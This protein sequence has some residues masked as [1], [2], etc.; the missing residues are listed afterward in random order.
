MKKIF[1]EQLQYETFDL[2]NS[3]EQYLKQNLS[4]KYFHIVS[5]KVKIIIYCT[6]IIDVICLRHRSPYILTVYNIV[7]MIY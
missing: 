7:Q 4:H 1:Q 2:S 5:G 3:M 6:T